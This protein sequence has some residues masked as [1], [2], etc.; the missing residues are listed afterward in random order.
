MAKVQGEEERVG[1][2]EARQA[3]ID[4]LT[5]VYRSSAVALRLL[6]AATMATIWTAVSEPVSEAVAKAVL[7]AADLDAAMDRMP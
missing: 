6:R 7:A 3:L 2:K 5:P 4:A 1:Y